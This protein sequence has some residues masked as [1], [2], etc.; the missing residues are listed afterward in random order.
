MER[1]HV[2]RKKKS[3]TT[4][5]TAAAAAASRSNDDAIDK[6]RIARGDFKARSRARNEARTA[7]PDG[8]GSI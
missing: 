3:L 4:K 2:A 1:R 8:G 7:A 5:T 6:G